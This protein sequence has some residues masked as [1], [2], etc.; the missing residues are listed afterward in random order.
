MSDTAEAHVI[1]HITKDQDY[2]STEVLEVLLGTRDA[3]WARAKE[4]DEE[5]GHDQWD[6]HAIETAPVVGVRV[7]EGWEGGASA[8]P[9]P[10]FE[11]HDGEM[12]HPDGTPLTI[13]P[14]QYRAGGWKLRRRLVTDWADS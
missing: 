10:P 13:T 1:V 3:A 6:Y 12:Y 5:R 2:Q 9:L 4:L 8:M 11:L 7:E 14:D